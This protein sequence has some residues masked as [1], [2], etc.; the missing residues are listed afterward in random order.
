LFAHGH[1]P[2]SEVLSELRAEETHL[3]GAGLLGVF[4]VL[5]DR[6]S[7]VLATASGPSRS[8]QRL[9]VIGI[10]A[11]FIYSL[12]KKQK[13][14]NIERGFLCEGHVADNGENCHTN[15]VFAT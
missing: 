3:R 4:S 7:T 11:T 1:V 8:M 6:A 10:I 15:V 12:Y 5:A 14:E 9:G 2:L 13:I